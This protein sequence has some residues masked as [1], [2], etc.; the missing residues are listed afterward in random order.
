MAEVPPRVWQ[1]D[2]CATAERHT[3]RSC[4]AVPWHELRLGRFRG[5]RFEFSGRRLPL[6]R[7]LK[8]PNLWKAT[9][10]AGPDGLTDG[11]PP[12]GES[13]PTPRW[14]GVWLW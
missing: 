1:I 3:K 6:T 4:R 2:K 8:A 12:S 7:I 11:I 13:L 10:L 9:I 14:Q 5:P